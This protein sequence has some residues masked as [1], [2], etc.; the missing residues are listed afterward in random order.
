M[1]AGHRGQRRTTDKPDYGC[2][3]VVDMLSF[4]DPRWAELEAG[5]RTPT[6][7]RPLLRRLETASDPQPA[8]DAL[9]AEMYH[10]GDVGPGSYVAVPHVVRIHRLRGA[11]DWN[12][13]ALVASVDA[14]RGVRG[15]PDVPHWARSDYETALREMAEMGL[16]ELPR[17]TSPEAVR[18]I[19]AVLALAFGART[20]G[21]LL[22]EYTED[23]VR[24]VLEGGG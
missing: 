1:P 17:A 23:E 11:V 21:R 2:V 20:C 4:D 15:N 14:A 6:D 3:E 13:Y 7:L 9:W 22:I 18:S 10:Q 8:W 12:S 16:A 19:L 5:Y 24:E